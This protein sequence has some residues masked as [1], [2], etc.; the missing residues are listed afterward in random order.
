MNIIIYITCNNA[1]IV[2]TLKV[3]WLLAHHKC[4]VWMLIFN[5]LFSTHIF[6]RNIK[7]LFHNE[8][9]SPLASKYYLV[10]H[11]IPYLIY[12]YHSFVFAHKF[13]IAPLMS[14]ARHYWQRVQWV[15]NED[16]FEF[17]SILWSISNDKWAIL[18]TSSLA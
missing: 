9:L 17:I 14:F 7:Y 18:C 12:L 11:R 6:L 3:Y 1:V 15:L 16:N 8:R 5:V 4:D 2:V 10:P 13:I